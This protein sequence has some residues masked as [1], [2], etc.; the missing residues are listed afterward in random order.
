VPAVRG[1]TEEGGRI[2][3]G[4]ENGW[5]F[6]DYHLAMFGPQDVPLGPHKLQFA[7]PPFGCDPA[8]YSVRIAGSIVAILR[9]GGCSFGIKVI[10]AQKL[11]AVAVI[12]VNTDD[13]KT[14]RL[15]ALPDEAPQVTIPCL[16]VGRRFQ[17]FLEEHVRRHFLLDQH[18]VNVQPTGTWGEYDARA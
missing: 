6:F 7:L 16:M 11:G 18:V 13:S 9:G 15:M 12:I 8:T 10:N 2:A 5:A 17:L 4:G 14:M 1:S 3:V